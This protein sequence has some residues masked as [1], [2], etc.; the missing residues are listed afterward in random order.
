MALHA[1]TVVAVF[2]TAFAL[3]SAW[4]SRRAAGPAPRAGL[5]IGPFAAFALVGVCVVCGVNG[6]A[7]FG[8]ICEAMPDAPVAVLML[9]D[10]VA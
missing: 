7:V 2:A 6:P 5:V 1:A 10:G 3:R 4:R 8:L 9:R